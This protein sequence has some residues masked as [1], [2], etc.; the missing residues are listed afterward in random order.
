MKSTIAIEVNELVKEYRLFKRPVHR[1]LETF[2]PFGTTYHKIFRALDKVSFTVEKGETVGIIGRNGSG[3]STLL[4]LICGIIKPT[5][6]KIAVNGTISALLELGTGFNPEFSG[7]QNVFLNG[8]ILGLSQNEINDRMDRILSFADIG[9]FVDQPVK[10]YSSG[11]YVRLAFAVAISIDPDILIVD[12]ALS[13]GDE[14]FQRKCFAHINQIQ[15]NGGTILFVTHSMASVIELCSRA[16]LFDKGELLLAG[17]PKQV[18][19]RYHKLIYAPEEKILSLR[20]E[21]CQMPDRFNLKSEENDEITDE[22]LEHRPQHL[23]SIRK[24]AREF[25]NAADYDPHLVPVST[26]KYISKGASILSPQ[27]CDAENR[28]VNILKSGSTYY[29]NYDVHF[30]RNAKDVRFGMLIKT[31]KG[32]ELSGCSAS[33]DFLGENLSLAGMKVRVSFPF[34]C[35]LN[36]GFYFLNAGVLAIVDGVE[37]YLDRQLD[38]AMF[39]VD[40]KQKSHS[41]GIVNMVGYPRVELLNE[42]QIRP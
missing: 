34:V 41:T 25:S 8:S 5:A 9:D 15:K 1:I 10:S 6:G 36:P 37:E 17:I 29:Y 40:E 38:I 12:E 35:M 33:A 21:L 11:M 23:E 30:D 32:I 39:R 26:V 2:F 27:I 28:E 20:E 18:V 31:I 14:A 13:V 7:R 16:F 3:K 4:Q 24:T 42:V 19:G 22:N